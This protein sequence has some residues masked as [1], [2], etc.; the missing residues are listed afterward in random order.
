M[1]QVQTSPAFLI[2]IKTPS[3]IS[4]KLYSKNKVSYTKNKGLQFFLVSDIWDLSS[5]ST[6]QIYKK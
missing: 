2:D 5:K 3:P 4:T 6:F 1:V